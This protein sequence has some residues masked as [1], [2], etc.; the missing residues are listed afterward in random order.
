MQATPSLA[1]D[2]ALS[3]EW[4]FEVL[5]LLSCILAW[6]FVFTGLET[7]HAVVVC[8]L[9]AVL[10]AFQ[11]SRFENRGAVLMALLAFA[12]V[13]GGLLGDGPLLLTISSFFLLQKSVGK[14]ALLSFR[15]LLA[16]SFLGFL[17]FTTAS[18]LE[19]FPPT[20]VFQEFFENGFRDYANLEMG[21]MA[22]LVLLWGVMAKAFAFFAEEHELR[23]SF[24]FFLLL[25]FPV[26]MLFFLCQ[27]YFHLSGFQNT[28]DWWIA[29]G[30]WSAT[31]SDPNAFGLF[32]LL[33]LAPLC[34][35]LKSLGNRF[36]SVAV[37][38]LFLCLLPL[39]LESGS[40]SLLLG[41]LAYLCFI[42]LSGLFTH[43]SLRLLLGLLSVLLLLFVSVEMT[44]FLHPLSVFSLYLTWR[45][46][47]LLLKVGLCLTKL[48]WLLFL[49]L[50]F[51]V[52][53]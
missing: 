53:A 24:S 37:A 41:A 8:L 4:A 40:R 52:M 16:G 17:I 27:R 38:L 20:A 5:F 23:E 19:V 12:I 2:R 47:M 36:W 42:V 14:T 28:N 30:R 25:F 45:E 26:S 21:Q 22:K 48:V 46:Y 13:F 11:R 32:V 18:L 51:W 49:M 35:K 44:F 39:G 1:L 6:I 29:Q 31:F 15:V 43:F 3:L 10:F 33:L 50:L 34:W 7:E 9:S